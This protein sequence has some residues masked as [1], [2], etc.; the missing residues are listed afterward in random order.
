MMPLKGKVAI[1]TGAGGGIG[2]ACAARL[3]RA[4]ARVVVA[5]IDVAGAER[6]AAGICAAG[7][8]AL[9]AHAD[10]GEDDSIRA[11]MATTVEAFGGLDILHNNAA[12][13]GISNNL[14]APVEFM[15]IGVWD[16]TMRINL[17]GTMLCIKYA[18]ALM[19]AR[20]G[21]SIINTSSAAA[22]RGALGYSAYACAK[23]GIDAL[24]RYVAA[25]HGKENIRCNAIA[26]GL[27]VSPATS[28]YFSG[29]AGAMMLAHHLTPRLGQP[30][31][32]AETVLFLASAASA[33]IT[34][35]VINVDGGSL[36]HQ[37]YYADEWRARGSA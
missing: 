36:S 1:V 13:T 6:Q 31:D 37:P 33:F 2:A 18:I 19:R 10:I 27:V 7:G 23:A 28:A 14:D 32:I 26:P 30:D 34:G 3:A 12:A 16:D 5:D 29:P 22:Q 20:G 11:L 21:G 24:T 4:G 17:R 8:E 15:D 25:Q 35:Q 9:P